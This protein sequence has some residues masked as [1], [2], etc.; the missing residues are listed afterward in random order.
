MQGAGPFSKQSQALTGA[1][2]VLFGSPTNGNLI[3]LIE[4]AI[5]GSF[6]V[7]GVVFFG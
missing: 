7:L 5:A 4:P 3:P 1:S 6:D 2:T